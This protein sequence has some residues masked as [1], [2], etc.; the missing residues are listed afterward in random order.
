[1]EKENTNKAVVDSFSQANK[2]SE[3]H[4]SEKC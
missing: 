1:M 4:L 3:D 2:S